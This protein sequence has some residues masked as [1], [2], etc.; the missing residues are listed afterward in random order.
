METSN[1][2]SNIFGTSS[3]TSAWKIFHEMFTNFTPFSLDAI[4]RLKSYVKY[5]SIIVRSMRLYISNEMLRIQ[6]TQVHLLKLHRK[7]RD[8]SYVFWES[9]TECLNL[10]KKP[11]ALTKIFEKFLSFIT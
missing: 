4:Q 6:K 9:S 8:I 11:M 2:N 3:S 10:S 1:S 7:F 5:A